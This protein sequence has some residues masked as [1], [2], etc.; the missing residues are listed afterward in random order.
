MLILQEPE[1]AALL[2]DARGKKATNN[3]EFIH[4]MNRLRLNS[5]ALKTWREREDAWLE[6]VVMQQPI[7]KLLPL[8]LSFL[9]AACSSFKA[10]EDRDKVYALLGLTSEHLPR[11]LTPNYKNKTTLDVFRDMARYF[12]S[13][14]DPFAMLPYAGI[15]YRESKVVEDL[16]SWA[17]DWTTPRPCAALHEPLHNYFET[18][19][20]HTSR[21][22]KPSVTLTQDPNAIILNGVCV[23]EIASLGS[24]CTIDFPA[25][26]KY[27]ETYRTGTILH[28]S[29]HKS[30]GTTKPSP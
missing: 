20:Y 10:S 3:I 14:R 26:I 17:P 25:V 23:D 11:S 8:P 13:S 27:S 22:S 24:I 1:M 7:K 6:T 12:L 4:K 5:N 16:P 29:P 30:L 21:T 18:I 15:G 2:T 28:N 9:L 19:E